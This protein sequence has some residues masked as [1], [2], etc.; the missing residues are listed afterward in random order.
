MC[1][2]GSVQLHSGGMC[3]LHVH[4]FVV[5]DASSDTALLQMLFSRASTAAAAG[6][7]LI[8]MRSLLLQDGFGELG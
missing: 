6:C 5:C 1:G 4:V 2:A 3:V 8:S 7:L